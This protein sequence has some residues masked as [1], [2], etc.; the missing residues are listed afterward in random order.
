MV[1]YNKLFFFGKWNNSITKPGGGCRFLRVAPSKVLKKWRRAYSNL[2]LHPLRSFSWKQKMSENECTTLPRGTIIR[3]SQWAWG[4]MQPLFH[5]LTFLH[6][7]KLKLT[8]FVISLLYKQKT[9]WNS[10]IQ[11]FWSDIFSPIFHEKSQL[12]RSTMFYNVIT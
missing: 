2:F 7:L 10:D 9:P 8:E 4:W 6:T 3:Q 1:K 5:F 11:N 12:F